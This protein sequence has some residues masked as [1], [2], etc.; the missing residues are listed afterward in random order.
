LSGKK[1]IQWAIKERARKKALGCTTKKR[2][3]D[4]PAVMAA[5]WTYAEDGCKDDLFYY[6]C[7]SCSGYHLTKSMGGSSVKIEI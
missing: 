7:D 2:Y 5:G 3:Q 4:I 6:R 1:K